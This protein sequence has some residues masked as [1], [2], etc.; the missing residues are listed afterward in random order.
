MSW[1]SVPLVCL[2]PM[3]QDIDQT[4]KRITDVKAR[5]APRLDDRTIFD[6]DPAACMR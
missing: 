2:L 4:F 3:L 1:W 5:H 6:P